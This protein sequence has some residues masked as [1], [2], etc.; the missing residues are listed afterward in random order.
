MAIEQLK[1]GWC[2][3]GIEVLLIFIFNLDVSSHTR[4]VAIIL[5]RERLKADLRNFPHG[6]WDPPWTDHSFCVFPLLSHLLSTC[7]V[8]S[9]SYLSLQNSERTSCS[10]LFFE[11]WLVCILM[12][13]FILSLLWTPMNCIWLCSNVLRRKLTS[14]S[15]F[16]SQL[17]DSLIKHL[18]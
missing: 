18:T 8:V 13:S 7:A 1:C 14:F 4:I 17:V 16:P 6:M 11:C 3:W 2:N 9:H 15:E 5:D 12:H 10:G